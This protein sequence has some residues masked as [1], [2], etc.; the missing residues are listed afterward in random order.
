VRVYVCLYCTC[1]LVR[2]AEAEE[3]KAEVVDEERVSYGI[4]CVDAEIIRM[5]EQRERFVLV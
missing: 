1:L 2:H 5:L 3:I 4:P